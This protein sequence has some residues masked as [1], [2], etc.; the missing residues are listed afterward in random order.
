[1]SLSNT[2][3]SLQDTMRKDVGV[4]GDAQRLGQLVWLLFL[5]IFDDRETEAE[6]LQDHYQSP[7]P[8]PL[9]WRNWAANAEGLTGDDLLKFLNLELFPGLKALEVEGNPRALV[10][11]EVFKDAYQYMKSGQLLRQVVNQLQAGINFNSAKDRHLFGELYEQLLC[12]LQNAGNAGEYYTP[13]AVTQFIVQMADPKLGEKILDPACGTGG[14]LTGAIEHIRRNQ[15][16]TPD[17]EARLQTSIFGVEKKPLPHLLCTTNML[18][19][20]IDVPSQIRHDNTLSRPLRDYGPQDHVDVVITNPPF[21]GMEEDGIETNFP[22]TFRTKETADLF[23]VLIINLLKDGGRC[24]LVLPDGT[25]FGG[26]VKARIKEELLKECNLHTIVRLPNS[27]FKPY[28]SIGT[29][30]L[31]FEK[32]SPTKDIWFYEH[33]VPAGQK[34]YSMT[35]PIKLDHLKPCADWWGGAKRKGRIENEVAWRIDFKAILEEARAKAKPHWEK[36]EQAGEA[37]AAFKNQAI[38]LRVEIKETDKEL[39]AES[40]ASAREKLLTKKQKLE[41][42]L[43]TAT[44]RQAQAEDEQRAAKRTGD[45][46]YDAAFNLDF[47]NPHSVAAD[48][49]EPEEVLAELLDAEKEVNTLR[50]QLKNILSEALA[51]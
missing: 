48:H 37:A 15:V 13:R 11:R 33:Q 23:L 42:K 31:F 14:F 12:D 41:A 10:V 5:K 43:E 44:T 32:G 47:K 34:A 1:M 38:S 7:I 30:L 45:G 21:G 50:E 28:A 40:K 22:A 35:R 46:I 4:D 8:E 3:K 20:G 16:K 29:N 19:H 18:V 36:A 39:A 26:G 49:G 24:A 9:R 17:D 6:L 2:I 25:L 27:V 51:R